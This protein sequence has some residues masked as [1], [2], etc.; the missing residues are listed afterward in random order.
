[1]SLLKAAIIGGGHIADQN[2]IPALKQLADLVEIV[3]VCGRDLNKTRVI[4]EQ[5]KIPGAFDNVETMFKTSK[6]DLVI[7]C[8]PNNLHYEYTMQAL[9]NGCHVLCEK[10]PAMTAAQAREMADLAKASG[11]VLAY[12]FQR[13]Q[14]PE[15]LLLKKCQHEGQLGKVYHIKANYLRRRGIPGWGNFTNKT[16]QGGG[17]LIDLGVHVLDLALGMLDYQMP[18]Q[19]VGNIYD[20][21]G[22]TGGKGLKGQW[23]PVKFDVDDACFAYLTFPNNASITLSCSFAL[24]QKEEEIVNL[25]VFGSKA[26]AILKPFSLHTEVAGELADINFPHLEQTDAQLKNTTAFIDAVL[27]KESNICSA[28]EGA[29]LQDIV[30]KI[31]QSAVKSKQ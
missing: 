8:T 30:E 17:A 11:K 22:K 29:V 4:A 16:I 10:P 12:N 25:E 13:R 31:Y 5:H 28:E 20:F 21:I 14:T 18:D 1:M 26:G 6:L 27:G 24:N 9:K 19:I 3:A 2:H 7:N 15:Y 23:D